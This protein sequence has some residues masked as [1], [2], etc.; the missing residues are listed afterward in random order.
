MHLLRGKFGNDIGIN[1]VLRRERL[2]RTV[3]GK[4]KAV[5]V[6]NVNALSLGNGSHPIFITAPIGFNLNRRTDLNI[7]QRLKRG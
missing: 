5:A 7:F 2:G 3:Y 4:H 1:A 6:G